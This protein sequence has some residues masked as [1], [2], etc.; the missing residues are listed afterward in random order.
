MSNISHVFCRSRSSF[1]GAGVFFAG[2]ENPGVC[3]ALG[4]D[5]IGVVN[6]IGV[7]DNIGVIDLIG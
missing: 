2:G 7:V 6:I 4:V 5:Y 1:P 3:T